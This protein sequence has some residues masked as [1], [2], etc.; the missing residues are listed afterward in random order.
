MQNAGIVM[1]LEGNHAVVMR[2]DGLFTRIPRTSDMGVG[3]EVGWE[4][5]TV[6]I[7]VGMSHARSGRR[8]VA[9][10]WRRMGAASIAACLAISAGVWFARGAITPMTAEAYA[11]VSVDINPSVSIQVDKTLHVMVAD[12][13]NSDGVLLLNHLDLHGQPLQRAISMVVDSAVQNHMMPQ[14]DTILVTTAPKVSGTNVIQVQQQVQSSMNAAIQANPNAQSLHPSVYA[15]GLSPAVWNAAN[16]AKMSPGKLAAY[17]MAA[18]EGLHVTNVNELTGSVLSKVLS[19]ADAQGVSQILSA[20]NPKTVA[21]FIQNLQAAGLLVAN[22]GSTG[23]ETPAAGTTNSHSGKGHSQSPGQSGKDLTVPSITVHV[24]GSTVTI[25]VGP[26]DA[27]ST[28]KRPS[29]NGKNGHSGDSGYSDKGDDSKHG[30]GHD[31]HVNPGKGFG[32]SGGR[33]HDN[34][35]HDGEQGSRQNPFTGLN[36]I[37]QILS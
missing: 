20:N 32:N 28:G 26:T 8:R 22:N 12:G 10:Q 34:Q 29:D 30:N 25:P 17:L 6:Q 31:D 9:S 3:M 24:G 1:E 37:L 18:K 16:K 35:N 36:I 2:K 5:L 15:V 33:G 14:D 27:T 13:I 7:P 4:A 21:Q 23:T 11:F 19:K